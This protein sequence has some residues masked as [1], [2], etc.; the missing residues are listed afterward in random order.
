LRFPSILGKRSI[1]PLIFP[2][3]SMAGEITYRPLADEDLPLMTSWLNRPHVRAFFQRAPISAAEVTAKYG[4]YI[5]R[6]MPT[7]SSL[8]LQDGTPFGYLQCYRVADWPDYQATIGVEGG[9]SVDLF[10]GEIGLVG[11]GLGRRML[12]GHVAQVAHPLYPCETVCWMGHELKNTA[13]RR[14]SAGAGF[15]EIREYDEEGRRHIL[16]MRQAR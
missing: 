1:V 12:A 11:K 5:R 10:I 9:V 4:P 13:A 6:E 16:M 3:G 8:A 15:T 7:H 2:A 14:C